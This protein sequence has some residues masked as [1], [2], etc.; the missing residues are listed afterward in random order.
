MKKYI[1]FLLSL[2]LAMSLSACSC[3]KQPSSE[4][5]V[6]TNP[7]TAPTV[8]TEATEPTAGNKKTLPG[9]M[10]DNINKIME[11]NPV[12][13][14]GGVIPIDLQDTTED[15]LLALTGY[16]G[17]SSGT[18]LTDGA[19]YEPMMGS[20]A[21]SLVL[22][23]VADAADAES[24]AREMKAN[25]DPR[26]WICVQADQIMAAGYGDVVMFIMLDSAMG[27]TAQSYVDAFEKVCGNKP[28]FTL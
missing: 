27:K 5:T 18:K 14:M 13:F 21:F 4:P 16:T 11:E 2:V 3:A 26:K 10:E 23:R 15:G 8:A 22:V 20:Q 9:T 6:V 28:D 19:V 12:E 1:A 25:I 7:T 17:L 24:V